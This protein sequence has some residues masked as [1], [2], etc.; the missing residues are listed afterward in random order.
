MSTIIIAFPNPQDANAIR[1][2]LIKNGYQ[3]VFASTSGAQAIHMMNEFHSGIIISGY[4]LSDM[5]YSDIH[6]CMPPTFQMLLMASDR[7]LSSIKKSD[8]VCLSMPLKVREL[9]E[10]LDMLFN[11]R[12][13]RKKKTQNGPRERSEEEKQLILK[14]KSLLMERNHLTEEEA[15]RYIQKCS[16]DSGTNKVEAAQMILAMLNT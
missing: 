9:M 1:A 4:K 12:V 15:H 7:A 10:T 16:M 3:A 14:A 2:I 13:R 11:E 8:M 5:L 6:D